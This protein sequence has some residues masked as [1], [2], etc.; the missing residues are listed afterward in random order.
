MLNVRRMFLSFIIKIVCNEAVTAKNVDNAALEKFNLKPG[1]EG[2]D[3]NCVR[4]DGHGDGHCL[5]CWQG[6]ACA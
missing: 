1:A 2:E 5:D 3:L 4:G 6:C